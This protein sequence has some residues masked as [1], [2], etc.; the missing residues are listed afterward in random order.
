MAVDRVKALPFILIWVLAFGLPVVIPANGEAESNTFTKIADTRGAL[1]GV[2]RNPSINAA[3]TVAFRA[4]DTTAFGI[5]TGSGGPLTTIADNSGA[6]ILDIADAE[7]SINAAGTVAFQAGLREPGMPPRDGGI[8]TGSG[9]P[10]TTIID[11]IDPTDP[12]MTGI[13]ACCPSIND[14][15]TVAFFGIPFPGFRG[16]FTVSGGAVTTIADTS[17][18]FS[19]LGAGVFS[20]PSINAGGTVA[21]L[22]FLRTGGE[23]IFTGSGGPLTTIADTSGAFRNFSLFG[24]PAINAAGTVAFVA[25][26]PEGIGV[27]T[28]TGGPITTLIDPRRSPYNSI[29]CVSINDRG[30]V[31]FMAT[32]STGE[33]GIFTGPDPVA[34]KVI[35]VGD[36]LFGSTVTELD[37]DRPPGL[38]NN[39]QAAFFARLADLTT[40]IYRADPPEQGGPPAVLLIPGWKGSCSNFENLKPWLVIALE[41]PLERVE[42]FNPDPGWVAPDGGTGGYFREP[43]VRRIAPRLQAYVE[44]FLNRMAPVRGG[45][46]DIVAHS[47]G[48]LVARWY[49]EK[50][51]GNSK[52]RSL[53]MLGTPNLGTRW[54]DVGGFGDFLASFIKGR[55]GVSDISLLDQSPSSNSPPGVLWELN[56]NFR[57]PTTRYLAVAG[58]WKSIPESIPMFVFFGE[59]NDCVIP[60]RSARGLLSEGGPFPDEISVV[61]IVTHPSP[62]CRGD[63]PSDFPPRLTRDRPS[64]DCTSDRGHVFCDVLSNVDPSRVVAMAAAPVQA[65][66]PSGSDLATVQQSRAPPRAG[67][68]PA[69]A[70]IAPGG[71]DAHPVSVDASAAAA[72]FSLFWMG[73]ETAVR[74]TLRRPDGSLVDP[75]DPDVTHFPPSAIVPGFFV[76]SYV[77]DS[78]A[79][80]EWVLHVTA[81]SVPPEGQV[82][83][84]SGSLDSPITLAFDTELASATLGQP[85]TL[86]ATLQ[87]FATPV[88]GAT[89]EGTITKPDGSSEVITLKDDGVG[90]DAQ[91]ND[92]TYTGTFGGTDLCGVYRFDVK[93]RGSASTG[94][95]TRGDSALVGV[96]FGGEQACADLALTKTHNPNPV[97]VGSDLTYAL[98]VRN[99]GP[100]TAAGVTLTDTLPADVTLVSTTPSQ[101]SCIGMSAVTCNLGSLADGASATITIVV[102]PTATGTITNSA[103]VT[104]I[105]TDPNTANN[106]AT[107]TTTVNA[108]TGPDIRGTYAAAGAATATSCQDPADNG[109]FEFSASVSIPSQAGATFSG[110]ATLTPVVSGNNITTNM[111]FSGTVTAGGEVSATFTYT[112]LVDGVFDSSGDGTFTGQVTGNT[113]AI[114]FSG[115]DRVGDTCTV[116]GSLSGTR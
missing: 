13:F 49:I 34:D 41:V 103:S 78:P 17:A 91:A 81:V 56:T 54:A 22:A 12:T 94:P 55:R 73:E 97:T 51:G 59:P 68:G 114:N 29:C 11:P 105:G 69:A 99:N 6:L 106:T 67:T 26:T 48:G 60:V 43:G 63:P 70:S 5:F 90:P 30:T 95:F 19:G 98:T 52:V 36:A 82:Y 25:F 61:R 96:L 116:T 20:K 66:L 28:G 2:G 42:C 111:S 101:G 102:T 47:Y 23:G 14:E 74:L 88:L 115:Q 112:T 8:F 100:D 27:F 4:F 87:E 93:A 35:A 72:A 62:A 21:F 7:P 71:A 110:S 18:V 113:L 58:D 3:G 76:E 40:G 45:K 32:L 46:I 50:L 85:V 10:L 1:L 44:D 15:G 109:T 53:T 65:E 104:G 57:M 16:I 24:D 77:V 31:A 75:S 92:G 64:T 38:N 107:V 89:V 108:F 86:T 33:K 9:G 79:V 80:D 37:F 84:V 39:G 83:V